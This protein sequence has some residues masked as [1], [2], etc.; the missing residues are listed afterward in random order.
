M[1]AI[2]FDD[3]DPNGFCTIPVGLMVA[4]IDPEFEDDLKRF[5][6]WGPKKGRNTVYARCD[7]TLPGGTRI[8]FYMHR[9]IMVL[10]K[11]EQPSNAHKFVDHVDGN[12][13]NNRTVNLRWATRRE[14]AKNIRGFNALQQD[15]LRCL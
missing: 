4:Q 3:F 10:A 2:P 14:N 7:H 8:R 6:T 11:I 12:G 1:S 15:M 13:L 9:V 5:N